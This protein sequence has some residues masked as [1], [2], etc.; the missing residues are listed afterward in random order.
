MKISFHYIKK[1]TT[2]LSA[3]GCFFPNTSA[4]SIWKIYTV[5]FPQMQSKSEK[6]ILKQIQY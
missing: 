1:K 6:A 5:I 3:T 4:R 2:V